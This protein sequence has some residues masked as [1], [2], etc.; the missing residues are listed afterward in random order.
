MPAAWAKWPL[1]R[2]SRLPAESMKVSS[3]NWSTFSS[4]RR[5]RHPLAARASDEIPNPR[6]GK[7]DHDVVSRPFHRLV[8]TINCNPSVLSPSALQGPL[9][10]PSGNS[11]GL[12]GCAILR[13]YADADCLNLRS[14]FGGLLD[15]LR[16][17]A[18]LERTSPS[19]GPARPCAALTKPMQYMLPPT[20][21]LQCSCHRPAAV[22]MR[23]M[24]S[25]TAVKAND[26]HGTE[27]PASDIAVSDRTTPSGSRAATR[28]G[29]APVAARQSHTATMCHLSMTTASKFT[30][31]CAVRAF[32]WAS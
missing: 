23:G 8:K 22:E 28:D 7:S 12:S 18:A 13:L 6:R 11:S 29:V 21:T 27:S 3:A 24:R 32:T 26:V 10:L 17:R 20:L 30:S 31:R 9:D 16:L 4:G 15:L 5:S 19:H 1:F 14:T 25:P 2:M